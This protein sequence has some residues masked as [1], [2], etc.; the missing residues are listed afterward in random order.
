MIRNGLRLLRDYASLVTRL[1][2]TSGMLLTVFRQVYSENSKGKVET[3]SLD[4]CWW[5]S[6]QPELLC[7]ISS[8]HTDVLILQTAPGLRPFPPNY[9]PSPVSLDQNLT[10]FQ[11]WLKN[12]EVPIVTLTGSLFFP[13]KF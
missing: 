11:H 13:E 7:E 8:S 10:G 12:H 4:V 3:L 6:P 9:M 1:L 2:A 5:S